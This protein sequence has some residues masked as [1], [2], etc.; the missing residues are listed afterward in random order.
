MYKY[1]HVGVSLF[2]KIYDRYLCGRVFYRPDKTG[3]IVKTACEDVQELLNVYA[4]ELPD[5]VEAE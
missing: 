5:Y 4:T 2:G 1:Y 3:Y